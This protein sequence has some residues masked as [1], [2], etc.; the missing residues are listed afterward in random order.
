MALELLKFDEI[1]SENKEIFQ[2][3][4]KQKYMKTISSLFMWDNLKMQHLSRPQRFSILDTDRGLNKKEFG[5]GLAKVL[6][7]HKS[8]T[9]S[10]ETRY[11]LAARHLKIIWSRKYIILCYVVSLNKYFNQEPAFVLVFTFI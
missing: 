6:A 5:R 8:R 9:A 1:T 7:V 11:C 4:L 2:K 3:Q 10:Q